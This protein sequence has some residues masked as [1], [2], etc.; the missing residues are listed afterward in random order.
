VVGVVYTPKRR[1]FIGVFSA[2][3]KKGDAF[4]A[5]QKAK[6]EGFLALYKKGNLELGKLVCRLFGIFLAK[7]ELYRF[8]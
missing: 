3:Y 4:T 7:K 6:K 2:Y 1:V 5:Y 8:S